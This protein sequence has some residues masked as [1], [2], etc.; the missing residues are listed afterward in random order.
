MRTIAFGPV[1]DKKPGSWYWFKELMDELSKYYKI[2][3]ITFDEKYKADIT[4]VLKHKRF[5]EE[6][7]QRNKKVIYCS[8]D[9]FESEKETIQFAKDRRIHTHILSCDRLK[10]YFQRE[11]IYVIHHQAKFVVDTNYNEFGHIIWVGG[12]K[13]WPIVKRYVGNRFG[14]TTLIE[15][16]TPN[17]QIELFKSARLA[18]DVKDIATFKERNKPITKVIDYLCSGIPTA[19]NYGHYAR[20]FFHKNYLYI[21]DPIHEWEYWNKKE[22]W[23]E[24]QKLKPILRANFLLE[25]IGQ[26]YKKVIDDA[27]KN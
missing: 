24:V 4:I 25:H 22:Y 6:L 18:I 2:K 20:E 9:A 11:N 26:Q 15:D 7:L 17:K 5:L 8:V 12:A 3:Y 21:P 13:N 10:Y 27:I 19:V 23:M 14:I 1:R 16:W